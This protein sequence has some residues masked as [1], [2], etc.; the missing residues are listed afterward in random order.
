MPMITFFVVYVVVVVVA[1]GV[2]FSAL[3]DNERGRRG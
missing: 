2:V 1:G 3:S